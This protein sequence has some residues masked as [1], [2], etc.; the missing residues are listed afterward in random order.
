MPLVSYFLADANKT[1]QQ[2]KS[3]SDGAYHLM[4]E[5]NWPGNV[6]EIKNVVER[7]VIMSD[8]DC[9][10]ADDLSLTN[11]NR[12]S[13]D[14]FEVGMDLKEYLERIEFDYLNSTYEKFHSS[15]L[16]AKFLNMSKATFIRKRKQYSEKFS[17][18]IIEE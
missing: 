7:A 2:N 16:A 9:I 18:P 6:I 14:S 8:N 1:Y 4:V 13:G 17:E 10:T 11:L 15:R 5:Y 3:F 12:T